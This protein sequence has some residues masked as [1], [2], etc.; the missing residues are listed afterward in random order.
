ML[1]RSDDALRGGALAL[2]P[3]SLDAANETGFAIGQSM[4]ILKRAYGEAQQLVQRRPDSAV[5]HH[6]L[7][8]VLRLRAGS[9]RRSRVVSVT[10]G[11]LLDP[12]VGGIVLGYV[13]GGR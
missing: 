1:L 13:H 8:Y 7:S 2:D 5:A 6:L 4:A 3:D 12:R 10:R 9:A 11:A